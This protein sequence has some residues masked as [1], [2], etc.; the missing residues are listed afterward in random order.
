V[1]C[2]NGSMGEWMARRTSSL[3]VGPAGGG[4][5]L[6]SLMGGGESRFQLLKLLAVCGTR[7]SNCM[8]TLYYITRL[9]IQ[10]TALSGI[11]T[12]ISQRLRV[13]TVT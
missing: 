6:G 10:I 2:V 3:V 5:Y 12:V 11:K 13:F 9:F 4:A 7:S 1:L 8:A